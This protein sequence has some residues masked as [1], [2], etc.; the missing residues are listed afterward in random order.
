MISA[1]DTR[2]KAT[3]QIPTDK[4]RSFLSGIATE[5]IE[6]AS[7]S[8]AGKIFAVD[9][10]T[11]FLV[12]VFFSHFDEDINNALLS[13]GRTGSSASP[14]RMGN[15]QEEPVSDGRSAFDRRKDL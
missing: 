10:Q 15:P 5:V 3:L 6:K 7:Y 2:M 11:E 14:A 4:K 1:Y 12:P 8:I 9:I 13:S